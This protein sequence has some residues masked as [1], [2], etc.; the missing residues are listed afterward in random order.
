MK[1]E[2]AV[3]VPLKR[4]LSAV[5]NFK[6]DV[7]EPSKEIYRQVELLKKSKYDSFSWWTKL[8]HEDY[9]DYYMWNIK[10][11]HYI[12]W[13]EANLAS[14]EDSKL[15]GEY[16]AWVNI[17][18]QLNQLVFVHS[19]PICLNPAQAAFVDKWE[20]KEYEENPI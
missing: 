12:Y 18:H 9:D 3:C 19:E 13:Y 15:Y 14:E 16:K 1:F 2:G 4:C 10:K 8:W 17:Y 11:G 20:A 7:L 5:G 6:K